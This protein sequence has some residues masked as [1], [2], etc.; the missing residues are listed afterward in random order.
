[1]SANVSQ[2]DS[3]SSVSDFKT[4]VKTLSANEKQTDAD[5]YQQRDYESFSMRRTSEVGVP[6][7]IDA[8]Y[9]ITSSVNQKNYRP[10]V[11][12]NKFDGN[13]VRYRRFIKQFE[14]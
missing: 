7:L 12:E 13:P 1:M 6:Q 10:L 2:W 11:K 9:S 3:R 5:G 8:L 4:N 14:T